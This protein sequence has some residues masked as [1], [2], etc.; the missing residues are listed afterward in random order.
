VPHRRCHRADRP[1]VAC[2][3]PIGPVGENYLLCVSDLT[4]RQADELSRRHGLFVATTDTVK[5]WFETHVA[6]GR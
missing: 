6:T 1:P 3:Q 5:A 2:A 4:E